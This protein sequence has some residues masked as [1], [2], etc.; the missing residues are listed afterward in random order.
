M[1]I[2]RSRS[3]LEATRFF[4]ECLYCREKLWSCQALFSDGLLWKDWDLEPIFGLI[5][6]FIDSSIQYFASDTKDSKF[7]D[8]L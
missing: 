6:R 2:E 3:E 5:P 4:L 7:Q 1:C 8:R